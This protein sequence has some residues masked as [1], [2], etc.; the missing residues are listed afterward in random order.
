M[1]PAE[2]DGVTSIRPADV[3]RLTALSDTVDALIAAA[4]EVGRSENPD[5]TG[6]ERIRLT[7]LALSVPEADWLLPVAPPEVRP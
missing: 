6:V 2:G 4:I 1:F 5:R 7:V 3:R